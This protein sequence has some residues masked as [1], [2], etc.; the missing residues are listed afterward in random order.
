MPRMDLGPLEE[1]Q[2]MPLTSNLFSPFSLCNFV[3]GWLFLWFYMS[4][5]MQY[6]TYIVYIIEKGSGR[7]AQSRR[8]TCIHIN[9]VAY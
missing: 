6:V 8:A 3:W 9:E 4:M 2:A 1:Q 7:Y 5:S